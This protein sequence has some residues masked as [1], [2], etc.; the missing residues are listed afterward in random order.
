MDRFISGILDILE[1]TGVVVRG[2]L[3]V[4]VVVVGGREV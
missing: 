1:W 2:G 3:I 4:R